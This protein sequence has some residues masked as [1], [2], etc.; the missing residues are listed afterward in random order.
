RLRPGMLMVVDLIKDR[1]QSLMIPEAAL[2]PEDNKQYVFIIGPGDVAE[3]TEVV[4]GRRRA[5]FVEILAGV[6]EGDLVVKE[7]LQNLQSGSRVEVV[8][9]SEVRTEDAPP[10]QASDNQVTRS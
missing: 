4:I 5:G 9:S 6:S 8:N 3:R 7:G 1:R 2:Q 10:S